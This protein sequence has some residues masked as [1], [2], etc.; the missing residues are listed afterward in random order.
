[1]AIL[2]Y[3]FYKYFNFE[4]NFFIDFK[5]FIILLFLTKSLFLWRKGRVLQELWRVY[6]RG[7]AK[8]ANRAPFSKSPHRG[9]KNKKF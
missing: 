5:R 3:A 4:F 8:W 7:R 9:K 6:K 2:F 1:M